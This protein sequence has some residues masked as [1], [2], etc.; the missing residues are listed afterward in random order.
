VADI[1][2]NR[3][4]KEDANRDLGVRWLRAQLEV[5]VT[6]ALAHRV[7]TNEGASAEEV[8]ALQG[9]WSHRV[10]L[11]PDAVHVLREELGW[12]D[13]VTG[14]AASRGLCSTKVGRALIGA[15]V[16]ECLSNSHWLLVIL[17]CSLHAALGSTICLL[18]GHCLIIH[19]SI[20]KSLL[21]LLRGCWL[22]L[23]HILKA[24]IGI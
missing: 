1:R 11:G 2:G 19:L 18:G 16:S 14:V 5:G 17:W 23:L 15:E 9:A 13:L 4:L 12:G 6:Q 3:R 24:L 7:D 21:I 22:H 8:L 20:F 10:L